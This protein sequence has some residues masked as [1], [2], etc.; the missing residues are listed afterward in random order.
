MKGLRRYLIVSAILLVVYL[1]AQY[2]KPKPTDWT[3]TYVKEDKIPFG[4]F[5]LHEQIRNIFPDVQ[6]KT[7]NKRTY[8]T[9]KGKVYKNASYLFIA[10]KIDLDKLDLQELMKFMS[11]GNQ[12]FIAAFD[13]DN[14]LSD[15]LKLKST[16][17]YNYMK[18]K[19]EGIN[20]T[21]PLLKSQNSYY[22]KKGLG[23]QYF[24]KF[25]TARAIVLGKNETGNANFLKYP[26]GKGTLYI[27]PNPQLLTN[28]SLLMPSGADYAAKVLSYLPPSETLI[29]DEFNTKPDTSDASVLRVIFRNEHLRW[30]YY[31][32]VVGLV[33]F[34]L[35]EMKRRQR[36]IPIVAPLSNSSVDFVKVVGQV[37][38][39]QRDNKDIASKKASYFLEHIRS[40]YHLKTAELDEELQQKLSVRS[41]VKADTIDQLFNLIKKINGGQK[42]DDQLLI[43]FNKLT[44]QFYKQAQ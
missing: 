8:N 27:L 38:Y 18:K 23:D 22:F 33:I 24:S 4:T 20:F 42:V 1:V 40:T 19:S 34:V 35:F 37:Y 10:S 39:Q 32:A 31:L 2:Y 36:I 7:T 30:A 14:I 44:E 5:I 15:T 17:S 9:L 28:Y 41:G 43:D 21:N 6:V 13:I 29:W 12:V 3:P 11:S 25:D 16:S 26:I